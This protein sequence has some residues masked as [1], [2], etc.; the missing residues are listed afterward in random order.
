MKSGRNKNEKA[1]D[2]PFVD[3]SVSYMEIEKQGTLC[4]SVRRANRSSR[5]TKAAGRQGRKEGGK[6]QAG[7]Y[8]ILS[9]GGR[10][11]STVTP[12]RSRNV[13]VAKK[14]EVRRRNMD[15][16]SPSSRATVSCLPS[17]LRDSF[18]SSNKKTEDTVVS[19]LRSFL[20]S[21]KGPLVF[22]P[23]SLSEDNHQYRNGAV[24]HG[25]QH[26]MMDGWHDCRW[27]APTKGVHHG[28]VRC[29]IE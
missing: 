2:T 1:N 14:A 5:T 11:A 22:S 13:S 18:A 9:S 4:G 20:P 28:A 15:I 10:D 23:K 25:R 21:S 12:T 24:L 7:N 6:E 8:S 19:P 29:R 26:G 27:R 17:E 3:G 16:P